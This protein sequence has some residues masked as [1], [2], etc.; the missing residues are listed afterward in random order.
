MVGG[1][2]RVYGDRSV[3]DAGTRSSAVAWLGICLLIF[4]A[5]F[6]ALRPLIEFPGQSLSSVETVLLA[7]IA[8]WLLAATA[9][10]EMPK[11]R[12]PLTWPWIAFL[13]A[14]LAASAA[15]FDRVNALHMV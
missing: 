11:W 12:T 2:S 15:G 8:A 10:G 14:M 4:V 1:D 6:E 3:A 5:P 7:V 13:A 9:L